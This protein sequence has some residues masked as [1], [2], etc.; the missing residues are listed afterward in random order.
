MVQLPRSLLGLNSS[1]EIS[2]KYPYP[3]GEIY[4]DFICYQWLLERSGTQFVWFDLGIY[5]YYRRPN[6][7]TLSNF[8]SK[9]YDFYDSMNYW[10]RCP[11]DHSFSNTELDDATNARLFNGSLHIFILIS[12]S[13]SKGEILRIQR[14]IRPHRRVL[15]NKRINLKIRR[16]MWYIIGSRSVLIAC[17]QCSRK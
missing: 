9:H 7:I 8:N 5:H 10:W 16:S 11:K 13:S 12:D 3:K 4:E 2:E 1:P 17:I 14:K 15:K 6:S